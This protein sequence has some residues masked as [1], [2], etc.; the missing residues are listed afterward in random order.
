MLKHARVSEARDEVEV[1]VRES[2]DGGDNHGATSL[3]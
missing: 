3:P 2:V 1:A